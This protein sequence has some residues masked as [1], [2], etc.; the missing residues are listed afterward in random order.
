M[1]D[2]GPLG[3]HAKVTTPVIEGIPVNV[4]HYAIRVIIHT[5]K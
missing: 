3:E 4:I 5:E 2:V 1:R